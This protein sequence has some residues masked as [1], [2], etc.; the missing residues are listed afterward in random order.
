MK[1]ESYWTVT[2]TPLYSFIFTL[3]LLL[4]YE[5]GLFAISSNDL[6]LLR[7]GADVLMRQILEMFGIVGTYGFGGTFLVG[8]IIAFI[9]QKKQLEASQINSEYLLTMLIESIGW[10]LLL[11]VAMI[12]APEYLMSTKDQRLLQQVVLAVGAGIYEEFVFRVILITGFAYILGLVFQWGEIGKN[13]VSI[14]LASAL[15]SSFH[16]L[17]PFGDETSIALFMIRLFAGIFLGAL[18]IFRG[19]GIAAYTHTIYD[20][21]VLIKFTTSS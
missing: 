4:V 12:R 9:R 8:F 11:T 10:A 1:S 13:F 14:I 3:P 18:Y 21:I 19:F 17:G 7:N 2:N 16:F 20:L 5:V 15:F 6:P